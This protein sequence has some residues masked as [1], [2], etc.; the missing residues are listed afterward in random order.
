MRRL[1]RPVCRGVDELF[2][3]ATQ[4]QLKLVVLR[5]IKVQEDGSVSFY[6][7]IRYIMRL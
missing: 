5:A 4:R 1:F 7:T 2:D 3:R 6:G